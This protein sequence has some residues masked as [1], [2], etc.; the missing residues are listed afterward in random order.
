M[1]SLSAEKS[2][3][4]L[5]LF[6][7]WRHPFIVH[8]H[9]TIYYFPRAHL[10]SYSMFSHVVITWS[11][12]TEVGYT[13][14]NKSRIIFFFSV[15]LQL[16]KMITRIQSERPG[17]PTGSTTGCNPSTHLLLVYKQ[18]NFLLCSAS[19]AVR[20]LLGQWSTCLHYGRVHTHTHMQKGPTICFWIWII[21]GNILAHSSK[22][23]PWLTIKRTKAEKR[24][25]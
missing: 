2:Q 5:N 7:V 18:V 16:D 8:E 6:V 15:G 24:E 12:E 19:W 17:V 11:T 1:T 4:W 10:H 23:V 9:S 20:M 13:E 3:T 14:M 25:S 22:Q 21:S